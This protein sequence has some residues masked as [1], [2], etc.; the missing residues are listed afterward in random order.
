M[1]SAKVSCGVSQGFPRRVRLLNQADYGRV[2]AQAAKSNDHCFTV[3]YRPNGLGHAR[4]GLA[5]SR[6]VARLAVAR[7]RIKRVVRE[8]FRLIQ[9]RLP[10]LDIVVIARPNLAQQDNAVL[11]R[12]L[13]QHWRRLLSS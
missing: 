9:H 3:L 10:A 1:V 6:K 8:S 5:V 12:S 7:N 2:F 11:F 4:L 13:E